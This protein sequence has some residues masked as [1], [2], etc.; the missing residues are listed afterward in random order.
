[1][2]FV[3]RQLQAAAHCNRTPLAA[4]FIDLKKAFDSPPRDA[5]WQCLEAI[6]CPGDLLA[7]IRAIHV[8]PVA[9]VRGS[10]VILKILR[11]VRQGCVL[12]PALF[13]LVFEFVLRRSNLE[14]ELGLLCRVSSGAPEGEGGSFK[15][16][17]GE[18]ADDG[19]IVGDPERISAALSR[20]Q[21]IGGRIGLDISVGKTEWLWL[22]PPNESVYT[23]DG[24]PTTVVLNGEPIKHVHSFRYLGS[25][26][27]EVGGLSAEL[28]FRT[29]AARKVLYSL[30]KLW[31]NTKVSIRRKVRYV[32]TK[33]FST[34]LYAC[35]TWAT[36]FKDESKLEV[37]LNEIRLAVL[38]TKRYKDF[39]VLPNEELHR[40][41]RLPSIRELLA[42][43][44]LSFYAQVIGDPSCRLASRMVFVEAVDG[45]VVS[46]RLRKT[47]CKLPVR[48]LQFLMSE[49][50]LSAVVYKTLDQLLK[51]RSEE[52]GKTRCRNM[53]NALANQNKGSSTKALLVSDRAKPFPCQLCKARF[54]ER[55]ELYR[56]LRRDHKANSLDLV[57]ATTSVDPVPQDGSTGC[58]DGLVWATVLTLPQ[59]SDGPPWSCPA[60]RCHM[61]YKRYGFL[62]R[63]VTLKHTVEFVS[64]R[65]RSVPS[66]GEPVTSMESVVETIV[67]EVGPHLEGDEVS[68][69]PPRPW[70]EGMDVCPYP[71]C[72]GGRGKAWSLKSWLNHGGKVH[73]WNF[74]NDK[75]SRAR[76][77][78]IAQSQTVEVPVGTAGVI[79]GRSGR[80]TVS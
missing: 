80:T 5:I 37:F 51:I 19:A 67:S 73:K 45:K 14:D 70:T 17:H 2:V 63:H 76:K 71:M 53:L 15:V 31:A 48:D 8:D 26:I 29:C 35:E 61:T 41:C 54:A 40:R 55:K 65:T 38:C 78:K 39:V 52:K 59:Q 33:V 50:D 44:R 13:G 77:T 11:G 28:D 1:M 49:D 7:M 47:W 18:F 74:A 16:A 25:T 24:D 62:E 3:L 75:P 9:C 36:T 34:L 66:P 68:N 57:E 30:A 56:H 69:G 10:E 32:R 23:L 64:G 79:R 60:D 58:V 43:R 4:A 6:G 72:R 22:Q 12:G 42:K 21:A 46:G 27:S 20:I